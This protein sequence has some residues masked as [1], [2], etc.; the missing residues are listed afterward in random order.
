MAELLEIQHLKTYFKTGGGML[1]AVDDISF[2]LKE[3]Q[4]LGVVGESGCGKS[5]LGRSILGLQSVTEGRV[6]FKG[7]DITVL[8]G[9]PGKNISARCR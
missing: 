9:M 5:T 6:L 8:E 7:D 2:T 1:H 4:T 3:G